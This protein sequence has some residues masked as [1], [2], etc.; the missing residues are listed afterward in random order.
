MIYG[1]KSLFFFCISYRR[2]IKFW[3]EIAQFYGI[4]NASRHWRV[5][6]T[7]CQVREGIPRDSLL[8]SDLIPW[9]CV[10]RELPADVDDQSERVQPITSNVE[11]TWH[12]GLIWNH[13]L[14]I[15]RG[16]NGVVVRETR[17]PAVRSGFEYW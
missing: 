5:H 11:V 12:S 10:V 15:Q 8:L 14:D 9:R 16:W 6:S 2:I 4:L 1:S 3:P 17:L 7:C 13:S